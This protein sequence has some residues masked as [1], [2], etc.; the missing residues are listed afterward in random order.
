KPARKGT[1]N[2]GFVLGSN[3]QR[4]EPSVPPAV[5]VEPSRPANP[6]AN[7][8]A[9]FQGI[10]T[11]FVEPEVRPKLKGAG[12]NLRL[13][14]DLGLDS[15]DM[16]EVM[17]RVED[18]LKIHDSDEQLRHFRTLGEVREFI[19]RTSRGMSGTVS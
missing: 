14:E 18:L 12:D 6:L 3:W 7:R 8:P 4:P 5:N 11:H 2:A 1:G 16:M 15:L 19:D 13:V 10:I 9:I 17:I